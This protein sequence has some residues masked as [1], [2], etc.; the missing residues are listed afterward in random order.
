MKAID[1]YMHLRNISD[2]AFSIAVASSFESFGRGSRLG[3]PIQVL[4]ADQIA[5]GSGVLI[6]PGSMLAV[7]M[8]QARI[9]IGDG[10]DMTGY[11]VLSAVSHVRV[12]RNVL[13]GRNVHVADHRHGFS[14]PDVPVRLQP[15]EDPR[16]VSIEDGAWLG[17]NVMIL[18][19]VT[20]GAGAVV[21][22]NSVVR[23]AVPPR[24]V[25]AGM[26]ARVIRMLDG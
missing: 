4:G 9:E 16:P 20:I 21:G 26:P 6:G 7:H 5:I 18:P 24:S 10:T 19:G 2:R 17:Q 22:A 1:A 14:T 12:G 25:A 3:L 11:C 23:E 13:F 15:L 8:P